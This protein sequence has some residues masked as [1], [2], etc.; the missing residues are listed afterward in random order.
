MS[1]GCPCLY[2]PCQCYCHREAGLFSGR[3]TLHLGCQDC[4]GQLSQKASE[5]P[6][7]CVCPK[8]KDLGMS[9]LPTHIP[10]FHPNDLY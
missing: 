8:L 5:P 7:G 1:S 4:S 10:C 9:V 6:H 2:G 3:R